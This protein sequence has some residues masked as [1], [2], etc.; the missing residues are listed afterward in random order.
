MAP[1]D[2]RSDAHPL[3]VA[4]PPDVHP[5]DIVWCRRADGC[6][7]RMIARSEPLQR[8]SVSVPVSTMEDWERDRDQA[9]AVHWPAR[10]V[11]PG[12]EPAPGP[13]V[14]TPV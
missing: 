5:G 8:T 2:A 3:A 7:T 4:T 10:D 12:G 6:V 13:L 1:S 11:T 14:S 9:A